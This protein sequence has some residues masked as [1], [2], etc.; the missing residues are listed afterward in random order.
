MYNFIKRIID[1]LLSFIALICFLPIFLPICVILLLTGEHE[2]FYIQKRVGKNAQTFYIWKFA[3][4]LK[5]SEKIGAGSLTVRNDP[6]VTTMGRFLR[7]TKINELPQII[8]VLLGSMSV[9]G[10]RPLLQSEYE[11]YSEDVQ[12]KVYQS[13]PGITGIGSII[14]RDEEKIL[15]K[16]GIP[17]EIYE[18]KIAPYKGELELWYQQHISFGVD[19]KII[20]LTLGVILFPKSELHYKWFKNLPSKPDYLT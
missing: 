7:K 5:N 14:F 11:A 1:L 19:I 6:R 8:N 10:P 13:K 2:V 9:V 12:Q 18:T 3:T 16:G 4:M 15:S 20:I 17:R